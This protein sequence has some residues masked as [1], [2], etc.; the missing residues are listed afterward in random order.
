MTVDLTGNESVPKIMKNDTAKLFLKTTITILVISKPVTISECYLINGRRCLSQCYI[1]QYASDS[2][3]I[4]QQFMDMTLHRC[5]GMN[6][7]PH[8]H[9]AHLSYLPEP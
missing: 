2:A 6:E 4:F 3:F 9:S 7:I 1:T 5:G 8:T